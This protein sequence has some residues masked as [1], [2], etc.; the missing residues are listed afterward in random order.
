MLKNERVTID[1]LNNQLDLEREKLQ[2]CEENLAIHKEI[3]QSVI[4]CGKTSS[5][6]SQAT[7]DSHLCKECFYISKHYNMSN[8]VSHL[9]GLLALKDERI[10]ALLAQILI[11]KKQI[12]ISETN[13]IEK[14]KE[15]TEKA[16]DIKVKLERTEHIFQNKEKKWAELERILV[17]YARNDQH[18]RHKLGEIKYICDDPSSNRRITTVVEENE[19][20]KTEMNDIR[21]EMEE[22]KSQVDCAKSNPTFF[23]DGDDYFKI[24]D[25]PFHDDEV[26]MNNKSL[27]K[28]SYKN[29]Q[30]AMSDMR[31]SDHNVN[32]GFMQRSRCESNNQLD[33]RSL[34]GNLKHERYSTYGDSNAPPIPKLCE[35]FGPD[36]KIFEEDD[37]QFFNIDQD[38]L[39]SGSHTEPN[40][41]SCD[42]P[43][44]E[45]SIGVIG[46]KRSLKGIS[47]PKSQAALD[48][49]AISLEKDFCKELREFWLS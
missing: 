22:L 14:E 12:N 11:L 32:Q 19:R 13:S 28:K 38:L 43:E 41:Y 3:L 16:E 42:T 24:G 26:P 30:S 37:I 33:D 44:L 46:N 15:L 17:V 25:Q 36:P 2:Q 7:G 47:Y 6:P 35:S 8:C 10:E 49:V 27:A 45:K 20:L 29:N 5:G 9:R 21:S 34:L 40:T 1:Y 4:T 48:Q 23:D 18:L 39:I 31:G